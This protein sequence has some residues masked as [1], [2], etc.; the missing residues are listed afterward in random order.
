MSFYYLQPTRRGSNKKGWVN[1]DQLSLLKTGKRMVLC[2]ATHCLHLLH[3]CDLQ[4]QVWECSGESISVFR[5]LYKC[6][7]DLR[8]FVWFCY[9]LEGLV[10]ARVKVKEMLPNKGSSGNLC[11]RANPTITS[12][13]LAQVSISLG[14]LILLSSIVQKSLVHTW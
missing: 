6:K 11:F 13:G 3:L 14:K 5:E 7:G 1:R 9:G 2:A 10:K 12:Q 4:V 8:G